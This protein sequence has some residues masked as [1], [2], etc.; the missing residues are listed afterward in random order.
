M[1]NNIKILLKVILVVVI[2]LNLPFQKVYSEGIENVV[3]SLTTQE[4]KQS[5]GKSIYIYNTH[6]GEKYANK[7][8]KE[9]SR[10]LMEQLKQRGY[11]VNY[12]TNDF[13]LYKAK[14]NIDYKYS[15][16][17]SKKY[18]NNAVKEHGQY[19]LVI[20][21]HRDSIKKSLSTITYENKSYA[22][23]MF[24]VGKGSSNYKNV[25]KM[26]SEL[27]N[28]LNEKIPKISR[29]IYV[30]Q[31]HYNQDTTKNMVLIEVGA[32]ENTYEEIQNSL[33]IL[34]LVID[35]YLSQ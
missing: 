16:T 2:I 12:E 20:D 15:Y 31:S 13:E 14:N 25:K 3:A 4:V 24:V 22:K 30:K 27:S 33:N 11:E 28:M 32:N 5:N 26:S 35:E 23:L 29:G 18:I 8:V 17:V 19:D 10:Y 9:G 21:F 6:Q 34:T 1:N 7:S